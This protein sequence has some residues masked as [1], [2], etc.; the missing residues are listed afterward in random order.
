MLHKSHN[1]TFGAVLLAGIICG[2]I[3]SIVLALRFGIDA[4]NP[5]VDSTK[6]IL[7]GAISGLVVAITFAIIAGIRSRSVAN[8]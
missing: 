1:L 2:S 7:F 8:D 3:F 5:I 6:N 4:A